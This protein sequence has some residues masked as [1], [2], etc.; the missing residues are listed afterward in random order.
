MHALHIRRL[1]PA[2]PRPLV[3]DSWR[4]RPV[5]TSGSGGVVLRQFYSPL[6]VFPSLIPP[7]GS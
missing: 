2:L 7:A 6:P 4:A 3:A 5:V 1:R